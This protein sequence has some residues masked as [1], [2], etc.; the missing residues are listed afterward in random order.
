MRA[1]RSW[2]VRAA[3]GERHA[4]RRRVLWQLEQLEDRLVLSTVWT[5]QGSGPL[6]QGQPSGLEQQ[7]NPDVG[8]VNALVP[9]PSNVNILY[10]ATASGGIW[11]TT[12]ATDSNPVWTPLT[13]NQPNLS[14]GDLAL[15]PLDA[16]T[17][18]A[19][20]GHFSNGSIGTYGLPNGPVGGGVLKSTDGGNSWTL[21]GQSPLAEQNIRAILPTPV[22]TVSGQVVLAGTVVNSSAPPPAGQPQQGG[23]Y[24]SIDGGQS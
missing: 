1:L 23:V 20:T 11:R 2:F 15:S 7:G 4:G 8:A 19:G 22:T 3:K 17:L 9:D 21:R 24:R 16:N 12:D 14:I 5:A 6:L 10:A 18:Y 13:D